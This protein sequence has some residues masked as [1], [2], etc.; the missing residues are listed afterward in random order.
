MFILRRS[1]FMEA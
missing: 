1:E